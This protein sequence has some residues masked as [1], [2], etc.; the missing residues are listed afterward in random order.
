MPADWAWEDEPI[1]EQLDEIRRTVA[2]MGW[3]VREDAVLGLFS[4][5]KYVMSCST[6]PSAS[7]LIRS[8]APSRTSG[9]WLRSAAA[10]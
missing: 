8:C 4:F 10:R 7:Q 6:T 2:G 1:G 5:Q 3:Q 9:C